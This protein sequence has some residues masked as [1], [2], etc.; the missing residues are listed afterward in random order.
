MKGQLKLQ[1]QATGRSHSK[2]VIK[3]GRAVNSLPHNARDAVSVDGSI[4][5]IGPMTSSTK[6]FSCPPATRKAAPG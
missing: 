1:T 2:M 3:A 4:T 5:H 6:A